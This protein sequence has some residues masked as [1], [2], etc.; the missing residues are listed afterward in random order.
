MPGSFHAGP[1]T[2]PSAPSFG[3][4]RLVFT[5]APDLRPRTDCIVAFYGRPNDDYSLAFRIYGLN[6]LSLRQ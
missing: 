4:P 2:L 6:V 5:L 1:L 3:N